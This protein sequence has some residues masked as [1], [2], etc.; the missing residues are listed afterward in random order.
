MD[1][2]LS[3]GS[4]NFTQWDTSEV[5]ELGFWG[6]CGWWGGIQWKTREAGWLADGKLEKGS[7]WNHELS[8]VCKFGRLSCIFHHKNTQVEN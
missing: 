4:G 1:R 3:P 5:I 6:M 7:S 8:C 2:N